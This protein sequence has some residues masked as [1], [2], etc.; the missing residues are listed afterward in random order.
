MKDLQKTAS[1]YKQ[2]KHLLLQL[3]EDQ[4]Q[5]QKENDEYYNELQIEREELKQWQDYLFQIE[6]AMKNE[7]EHVNNLFQQHNS[8]KKIKLLHFQ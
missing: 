3:E 8:D 6:H 5:R 4:K 1:H 7:V 2:Y